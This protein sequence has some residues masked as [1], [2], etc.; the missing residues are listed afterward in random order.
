MVQQIGQGGAPAFSPALASSPP[1]VGQSDPAASS[2]PVADNQG[3]S[4]GDQ[5]AAA[6]AASPTK[7]VV[8]PGA[9][10]MVMVFKV[11]DRST[12]AV[13]TSIPQEEAGK[14][15]ADPNYSAGRFVNQTA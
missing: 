14:A 13:L 7:V 3:P 2:S 9:N 5:A 6:S 12:G 11:L 15:A 4:Q 8:E 1:P 10:S